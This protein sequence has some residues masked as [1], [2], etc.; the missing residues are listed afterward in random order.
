LIALHLQN[1]KEQPDS[2]LAC[3]SLAWAYLMAP[4]ALRDVKAALPLA[5][6]ALH[7]EPEN[8]AFR[9]T[10]GLAYVRAGQYAS[11]IETLLP[12]LKNPNNPF[13]GWDLFFLAMAHHHMGETI[14]SRLYYNLGVIWGNQQRELDAD[15]TEELAAIRTE[16]EAVLGSGRQPSPKGKP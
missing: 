3:D 5:Q 12:D 16:A 14:Q 11:A 4:K 15:Q 7:L 2:A 6:K 9:N 10:L 1:W 13:L 8:P